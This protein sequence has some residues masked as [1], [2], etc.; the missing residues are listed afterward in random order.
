MNSN[1]RNSIHILKSKQTPSVY[2][3]IEVIEDMQNQIDDLKAQVKKK[4]TSE[5]MLQD[6]LKEA[7]FDEW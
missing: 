2:D 6:M 5:L 4:K 1:T 3:L 7:Q